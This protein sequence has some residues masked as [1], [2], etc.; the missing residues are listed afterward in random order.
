MVIFFFFLPL[1]VLPVCDDGKV[2]G[3][4]IWH[5]DARKSWSRD[6]GIVPLSQATGYHYKGLKYRATAGNKPFRIGGRAI[7][8]IVATHRTRVLKPQIPK[9][10]PLLHTPPHAR[11]SQIDPHIRRIS[12][13][14][15]AIDQSSLR[16]PRYPV[17][18]QVSEILYPQPT[19]PN[20]GPTA[21]YL[22]SVLVVFEKYGTLPYLTQLI[23]Y[24]KLP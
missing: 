8:G 18:S 21:P 2:G 24:G 5:P 20:A 14:T 12:G 19:V 22:C 4:S 16:V 17:T 1:R 23:P 10:R 11:F 13:K 6:I 15:R 3:A 7:T 9:S